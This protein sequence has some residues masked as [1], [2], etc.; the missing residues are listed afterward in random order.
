MKKTVLAAT[1]LL[2]VTTSY[3]GADFVDPL[4]F[5]CSNCGGDNGVFTPSGN[6]PVGI[7]VTASPAQS[8]DLTLKVLIPNNDTALLTDVFSGTVNSNTSFT[9]TAT[10]FT[11]ATQGTQWTT[12]SLEGSFLGITNFGTGSPPNDITAFLP[13]TQAVDPG[14]TGFFVLT[15]DVGAVSLNVPGGSSPINLNLANEFLG[16]WVMGDLTSTTQCKTGVT[17]CDVTTAQSAALFVNPAAVPGPIVGAGLPGL[18]SA[19]LGLY[20]LNRFRRRR[21]A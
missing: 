9:G 8:G 15:L 18:I 2:A 7:T 12:G 10:L 16:G 3:A 6:P 5:S 1:A 19:L 21:V 14:A 11:S 17:S 4:H 13:S 20:G